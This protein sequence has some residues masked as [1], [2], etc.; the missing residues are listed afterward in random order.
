MGKLE[1]SI[2]DAVDRWAKRTGRILIFKLKLD[3]NAGWPDKMYLLPGNQACF[4]EFKR[5]GEEPE[6]LQYHRIKV[7]RSYQYEVCWTRS[8]KAA[9]RWLSAKLQ[10]APVPKTRR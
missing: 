8:S 4:I 3:T 5:A 1:H 10:A 6:P 7:L 9:I 2:E